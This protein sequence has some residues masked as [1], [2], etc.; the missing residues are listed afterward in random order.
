VLATLLGA[1]L[2]SMRDRMDRI[3][4]P[5]DHATVHEARIE[6]KRLRYLLEPLRGYRRA[7]ASEPVRHLKNLQDVL[8]DLHDGHLLA[9]ELRDALVDAAAE[10]ARQVHAAVYEEGASGAALRDELRASPRPGLL[11]VARLVRE[12]RD[13]LH[14]DLERR[15][16][17][18]GLDALE[19]EVRTIAAALEARAGGK[20]ERERRYPLAGRPHHG[21]SIGPG[22]EPRHPLAL[23]P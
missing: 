20:L 16:R 5:S 1:Q 3:R 17:A 2:D 13:A 11:A 10:R 19:T 18:G 4:G 12:R 21:C 7:D 9:G 8:G 22:T 23:I 14:A 15:W 6:A